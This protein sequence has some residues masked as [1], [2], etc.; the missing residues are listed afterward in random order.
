MI[1]RFLPWLRRGAAS[2]ITT[3]DSPS[4]PANAVNTV[5]IRVN[6][7]LLEVP[8]SLHGPGE[9]RGIES[10]L[11]SRQEPRP[12][13]TDHAPNYFAAIEWSDEDFPG[14]LLLAKHPDRIAGC[15][16]GSVLW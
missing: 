4:A 6:E 8:L 5:T 1:L 10:K 11:V 2:N 7:T 15:V 16:R 13:A 9:V 3:T 12:N 14:A